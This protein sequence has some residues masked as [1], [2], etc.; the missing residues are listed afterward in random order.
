MLNSGVIDGEKV[1]IGCKDARGEPLLDIEDTSF[2]S[3]RDRNSKE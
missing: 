3:T 1:D 2:L